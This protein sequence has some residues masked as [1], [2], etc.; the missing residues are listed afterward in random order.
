MAKFSTANP[1]QQVMPITNPKDGTPTP[2]MIRQ[3][4]LRQDDIE[5]AVP[6]SRLI[7][8]TAP[9]TGGGD[10]SEDR[11]IGLADSGVTPGAYTSADITVDEWGR[12]TAAA[13]GGGGGGSPQYFFPSMGYGANDSGGFATLGHAFILAKNCSIDF[14]YGAFNA[15]A[16]GDIYGMFVSIINSSGT[17]TAAVGHTGTFT[18]GAS[19]WFMPEFTPTAPLTLTAGVIYYMGLVLTNRTTSSACRAGVNSGDGS[20]P[21]ANAPVDQGAMMATFGSTNK[22]FWYTQNS[23]T[24]SSG[25]PSSNTGTGVYGIGFRGTFA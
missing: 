23:L 17:F 4:Q 2:Y 24:P 5:G 13:N 22:R 1:L 21:S 3:M 9:L 11:T 12:V 6:D 18:T 8:T 25:G 7:S 10:L 19:G 15:N 14:L 16:S 20:F